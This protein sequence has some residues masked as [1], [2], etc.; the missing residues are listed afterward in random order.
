MFD[1]ES[2]VLDMDALRRTDAVV[3]E[4][5]F[6][7]VEYQTRRRIRDL[8]IRLFWLWWNCQN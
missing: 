1:I 7:R 2:G 3:V 6:V 5:E 8:R 4:A